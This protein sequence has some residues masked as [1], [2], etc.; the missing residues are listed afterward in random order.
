MLAAGAQTARRGGTQAAPRPSLTGHLHTLP[1]IAFAF[2]LHP[3]GY[4]LFATP[5]PSSRLP[6]HTFQPSFSSSAFIILRRL[7][8]HRLASLP[9]TSRV[10]CLRSSTALPA[11]KSHQGTSPPFLINTPPHTYLTLAFYPHAK[12][13]LIILSPGTPKEESCLLPLLQGMRR[14][15]W[16]GRV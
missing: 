12:Y 11:T 8:T 7:A 15:A 2:A 9:L 14:C 5:P 16:R 6:T 4:S 1:T 13:T 10:N 3:P